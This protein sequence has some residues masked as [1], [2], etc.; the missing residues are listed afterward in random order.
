[1]NKQLPCNA[2]RECLLPLGQASLEATFHGITAQVVRSTVQSPIE[3][4]LS[5]GYLTFAIRCKS[6]L[7]TTSGQIAR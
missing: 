7:F 1:M 5:L 6:R 4:G 2:N 3:Q